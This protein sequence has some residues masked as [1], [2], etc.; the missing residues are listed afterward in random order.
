MLGVF[1]PERMSQNSWYSPQTNPM[2][3]YMAK[4]HKGYIADQSGQKIV[5]F[6]NESEEEMVD[7]VAQFVARLVARGETAEIQVKMPAGAPFFVTIHR[8]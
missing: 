2:E 1:D 3:D 6:D 4:D 7:A 8:P 5:V